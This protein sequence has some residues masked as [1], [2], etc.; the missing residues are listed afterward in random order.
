MEG[1][2]E[3]VVSVEPS[4]R[5]DAMNSCRRGFIRCRIREGPIGSHQE[6]ASAEKWESSSAETEDVECLRIGV[7][8]AGW[9]FGRAERVGFSGEGLVSGWIERR[10]RMGLVLGRNEAILGVEVLVVRVMEN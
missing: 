8:A 5:Q 9:M 2:G 4:A 10:A 6:L 7:G 3:G 1:E